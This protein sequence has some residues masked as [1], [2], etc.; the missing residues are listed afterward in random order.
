MT[1]AIARL[2]EERVRLVGLVSAGHFM[3]HFYILVLPPLFP[4]VHADL[5]VTFT[6][7]GAIMTAYAVANTVCQIPMGFLVDR[8]GGR[9]VLA[10]GLGMH[11]AAFAG[12]YFVHSYWAMLA[13]YAVAGIGQAV[14]HPADYAILSARIDKAQLGRAVSVHTFMGN[15]GWGLAPPVI[16]ALTGLVD[17]RFAYLVVGLIGLSL[18]LLIFARADLLGGAPEHLRRV[19]GQRRK[20]GGLKE[21]FRLMG[22]PALLILFAYFLFSSLAGNGIN[23][24]TVVSL[25]RIYG[26]DIVG[27][28][29][30]LTGYLWGTAAG[31]LLGG[32]LVDRFGR[33]NLIAGGLMAASALC[34]LVIPVGGLPL[35]AVVVLMTLVGAF[36]GASAPSRDILV[37]QAAGP[38]TVGIAFGFTSTGF[39]VAAAAMPPVYGWLLDTGHLDIAFAV[40]VA[41]LLVA[42][43]ACLLSRDEAGNRR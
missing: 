9:I 40:M 7:L 3:S 38:T 34:L 8:F 29:S 43:G 2:G 11:G 10:V 13:L 15:V 16:L 22:S 4:L 39:S 37:R 36:S 23:N 31:V 33:P 19:D 1:A 42:V 12:V 35:V 5:G 14:F 30:A 17:W 41:G 18:A 25:M 6:M 26:V 20:S 28:N 24:I 32:W 21:G 27:A